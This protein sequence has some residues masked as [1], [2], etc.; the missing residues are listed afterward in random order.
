[1]GKRRARMRRGNSHLQNLAWVQPKLSW[2]WCRVSV[3]LPL[4]AA[5]DGCASVP[6]VSCQNG[7]QPALQELLYFGTDKP[8]GTV[9]AEEWARYLAETF[10]QGFPDGFTVWQAAGQWRSAS[11]E[12]IQE[13]SNVLSLVHPGT[14]AAEA[15]IQ[16]FM[17]AYKVGFQQEAVLRVTSDVCIS[18]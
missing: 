16:E 5:L 17:K 13:A 2:A 15:S 14:A 10:T 3:L 6:S 12:V 9:T 1:M 18:F 7:Q 11:G 8:D 4:L